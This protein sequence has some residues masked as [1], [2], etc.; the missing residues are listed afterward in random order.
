MVFVQLCE[1]DL[2]LQKFKAYQRQYSALTKYWPSSCDAFP[3]LLITRI[4]TTQHT[5]NY[6]PSSS[7]LCVFMAN[8]ICLTPTASNEESL[9]SGPQQMLEYMAFTTYILTILHR[10]P[11]SDNNPNLIPASI[12]ALSAR[13]IQS[14]SKII[15]EY[16]FA[17]TLKRCP[18]ELFNYAVQ[19]L[20]NTFSQ[21]SSNDPPL[22]QSW[23]RWRFVWRQPTVHPMP[24]HLSSANVFSKKFPIFW[25]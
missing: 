1:Y 10:N 14:L 12:S 22:T 21:E 25:Q 4:L 19:T 8:R 7:D 24:V 11:K 6:S 5:K 13:S 20:L 2:L 3:R 18:P 17:S 9:K 16:A 15:L 23:T